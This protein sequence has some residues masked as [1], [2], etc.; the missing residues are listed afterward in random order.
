MECIKPDHSGR[1]SNKLRL[2]DM[3]RKDL[4]MI[5]IPASACISLL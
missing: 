1:R 5:Y 2:P 3:T 4:A